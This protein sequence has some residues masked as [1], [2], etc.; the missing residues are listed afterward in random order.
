M[1][2]SLYFVLLL[3]A[4]SIGLFSLLYAKFIPQHTPAPL[5][6][7]SVSPKDIVPVVVIGSGPAGLT[8]A[9]YGGRSGTKTILIEGSKPGGALTETS[10]VENW[11]GEEK[12]LGQDLIDKLTK[13]AKSWG[14]EFMN[15]VVKSVDFSCW[16]FIISLENGKTIYAYSVIIAA[17]SS[18]K[19]L[20]IP[21]EKEYWGKGV[22]TCAICDAPFY[23][24]KEVVVIGGGDSAAEEALQLTPYAQKIYVLVRK[25]KMRAVDYLQKRL[26]SAPNIEIVYDTE[27]VEII[28]DNNQVNTVK[29]RDTST[30]E[31]R[32]KPID[33]VFLA[34]GHIPN[35]RI[36]THQLKLNGQGKVVL[37]GITQQTSVPGVFVA[38]DIAQ[39]SEMQA[40]TASG[41]GAKA[42][43]QALSWLNQQGVSL[44]GSSA[45][46][47]QEPKNTSDKQVDSTAQKK[48]R[49]IYALT[50]LDD[51]NQALKNKEQIIIVDFY[52]DYCSSCKQMMPH[53]KDAAQEFAENAAFYK[54][55]IGQTADIATNCAIKSL[56]TILIFKDGKE[57]KRVNKALS[58][59]E[60]DQMIH[61]CI[62]S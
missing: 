58:R 5:K 20:G 21:G 11:P 62:I 14:A 22:T 41:D 36:F 16:P 56:P 55:D 19:L 44:A 34:I 3:C 27:V 51:F 32:S 15:D 29:L 17:G 23:K 46:Q 53:M 49:D 25:S 6:T 33:G 35:T 50:S 54:V 7:V 10:Y 9:L 26:A 1:K 12:I 40:I 57:I 2:R 38:G 31:I 37:Q 45:A 8:A 42:M 39:G 30:G 43:L 47:K 4:G 48:M 13:H 18:P 59:L 24:Q 61:D 60:I 52:A 28:G